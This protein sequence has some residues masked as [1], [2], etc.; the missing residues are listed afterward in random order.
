VIV[1]GARKT[2]VA[3]VNSG[4]LGLTSFSKYIREAM[5]L[6]PHVEAHHINLSEQLTVSERLMRRAMCARVWPDGLFDIKNLDFA[7]L[8]QEYHAG[9]QAAGRLRTLMATQGMDVL[10]FHRQATAY[11]SLSLMRRVPTIVSIDCTQDAV[12]QDAD[13]ALERW[14]YKGNV[15]IDGAIFRAAKAIVATSNWA[16]EC[17]HRRY[18][19][20][21][22]PVHVMQPPVRADFFRDG[23]V[24]ER[25]ERARQGGPLRVLF[26]GGDFVRKGGD[27]LLKAWALGRFDRVA[28]LHIVTDWPV[29]VSGLTGVQVIKDVG[30]Y[31]SEWSELWRAADLFVLPTRSEAFGTVLQEAKAAGLPIVATRLN[32]VPEIVDDGAS[33][34]LVPPRDPQ[35]LADAMRTLL[36]SSELRRRFGAAGRQRMFQVAHPRDYSSKLRQLVQSVAGRDPHEPQQHI[37]RR[38]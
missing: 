35:A 9:F 3:F 33:G 4:I 13:T 25:F 7:R 2:H 24:E 38:A 26:V 18:P 14:T 1:A 31:S 22:T 11:C 29:D 15:A 20:C 8:R 27:D 10:H 16:A 30:A 12:I 23:W 21:A 19:D 36:D 34:L 37:A 17:V 6:D 5:A 32:A 28:T